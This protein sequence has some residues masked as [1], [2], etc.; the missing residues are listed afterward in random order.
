VIDALSEVVHALRGRGP[1]L[2]DGTLEL[3]LLLLLLLL[4]LVLEV[5]AADLLE[6]LTS[7]S[8]DKLNSPAREAEAEEELSSSLRP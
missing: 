5:F 1:A 8:G 7:S 4:L 2:L 3:E 6:R